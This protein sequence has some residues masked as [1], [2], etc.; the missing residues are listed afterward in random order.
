MIV[1]VQ[2]LAGF[3]KLLHY[4]VPE[5]LRASIQPGSLM[6]VPICSAGSACG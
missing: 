2:P 1:G 6:R 5:V 4:Q 3:D